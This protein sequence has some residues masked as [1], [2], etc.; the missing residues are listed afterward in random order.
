[1]RDKMSLVPGK[2]NLQDLNTK[3]NEF[4][5][6]KCNITLVNPHNIHL[7]FVTKRLQTYFWISVFI[8][9]VCLILAAEVTLFIDEFH[10]AAT[11]MVA[12]TS[13]LVMYT[14]YSTIQVFDLSKL[15][16]NTVN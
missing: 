2:L 8:P 10:F 6:I 14:L 5:V 15:N 3:L 16:N 9:S 12:L 11:I 7:V 4:N 1:M 13:N